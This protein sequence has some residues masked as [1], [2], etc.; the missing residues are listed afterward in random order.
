MSTTSPPL[1]PPTTNNNDA[2]LNAMKASGYYNSLTSEQQAQSSPSQWCIFLRRTK[3]KGGSRLDAKAT[4]SPSQ[5]QPAPSGNSYSN[6][7]PVMAGLDQPVFG[8]MTTRDILTERAK[9]ASPEYQQALKETTV[10]Q[11]K[12]HDSVCSS[13]SQPGHIGL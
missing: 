6:K 13:K 8:S 10:A 4:T 2:I 11:R 5:Q 9:A 3:G 1:I 12:H 7:S